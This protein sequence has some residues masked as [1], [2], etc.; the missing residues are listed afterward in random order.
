MITITVEKDGTRN[1]DLPVGS[2]SVKNLDDSLKMSY[3]GTDDLEI[4]IRGPREVLENYEVDKKASI[5]LSEL[6]MAGTYTVPVDIELP[7]GCTLENK[8]EVQVVLEKK[9]ESGG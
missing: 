2:I 3:A 5:D 7:A 6:K 1:L 9:E 8:V 4:H